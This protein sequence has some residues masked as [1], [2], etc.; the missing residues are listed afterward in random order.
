MEIPIEAPVEIKRAIAK[1][2][3]KSGALK[4]IER[5]IKLGMMVAV[6]E[7]REDPKA[8]GNLERRRFRDA[9]VHELR[10]L[11]AVY[12]FLAERNLTYTLSALLEESGVRRNNSEA[13][14]I[15]TL[16]DERQPRKYERRRAS[17]RTSKPLLVKKR[18]YSSED[19]TPEE[20]E[21]SDDLADAIAQRK[22]QG[23][24]SKSRTAV[25]RKEFER[26]RFLDSIDDI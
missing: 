14:D 11:Q 13:A 3:Q 8:P 4:R 25:G 18:R 6:E 24:G 2:L 9:S 19:D 22:Y 10:G 17:L 12:N 7:I 5:K 1:R 21:N 23:K 16:L 20:S 15:L 26:N